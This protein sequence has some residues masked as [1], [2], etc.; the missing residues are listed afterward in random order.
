ML[1]E[2]FFACLSLATLMVLAPD[3]PLKKPDLIYAN[4][5]ADFGAR[6]GGAV[7][8]SVDSLRGILLPF[9]LLCFATFV[10]DTLDACTRLARYVMMELFGW[11]T[12]GQAVAATLLSLAVP[13]AA[14]A[15]PRIEAGGQKQALWQVFWNI[16]GASNQLLA[17]LTLMGVSVWMARRR[18]NF[19]IALAPSV[20][21]MVMTLWSLALMAR[22]YLMVWGKGV[23]IEPFRHFQFGIIVTL[24]ALSAWLIA[25]AVATW[26]TMLRPPGSGGG[27]AAKEGAPA[28]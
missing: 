7:S 12:R 28:V 25:E 1:L 2:G 9:A 13:V 16:F 14:I 24:M 11:T 20:F 22:P 17:A 27:I 15:L 3:S 26:R 19:W 6:I 4:G 18:M 8:L 10:F 21:M 23:P 5:I